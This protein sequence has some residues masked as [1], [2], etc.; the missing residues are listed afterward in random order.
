MLG[1]EDRRGWVAKVGAARRQGHNAVNPARRLRCGELIKMRTA[2]RQTPCCSLHQVR[3]HSHTHR[4]GGKR[5]GGKGT[6]ER[7]RGR[8]AV[9][10][11]KETDLAQIL[12]GSEAACE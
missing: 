4:E 6:L 3:W 7:H 8:G 12:V 2:A 11:G 1:G 9:K 10:V 5:E